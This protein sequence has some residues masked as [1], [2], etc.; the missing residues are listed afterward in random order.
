MFVSRKVTV[1][2]ELGRSLRAVQIHFAS[3]HGTLRIASV[4]PPGDALLPSRRSL[5]VRW[6][7]ERGPM[8]GQAATIVV[9]SGGARPVVVELRPSDQPLDQFDAPLD[10]GT[11]MQWRRSRERE[12]F[13]KHKRLFNDLDDAFWSNANP[14]PNQDLLCLMR[15]ILERRHDGDDP[16]DGVVFDAARLRPISRPFMDAFERY[17]M[18]NGE[19]NFPSIA[20]AFDRFSRGELSLLRQGDDD[21]THPV[22][23]AEKGW[24]C[25][26]D[27]TLY[28]HFA[29]LAELCR[30]AGVDADVWRELKPV[31][32]YSLEEFIET[33]SGGHMSWGDECIGIYPPHATDQGELRA[34]RRQFMHDHGHEIDAV[35][36]NSAQRYLDF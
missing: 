24:S 9:E 32:V 19:L 11:L 25:Q 20:D 31:L 23:F 8:P 35:W 7:P 33:Y 22:P 13:K 12:P 15:G 27:S 14:D 21:P 34:A 29:E 16:Y 26:P 6:P 17:R 5:V 36:Q 4:S 30:R 1:E 3:S 2:N 18:A 28:F 10:K